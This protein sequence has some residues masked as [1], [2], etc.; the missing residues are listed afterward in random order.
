MSDDNVKNQPRKINPAQTFENLVEWVGTES[1]KHHAPGLIIGI[2]G[3]DSLLTYLACAEAYERQ[4]KG[5]RVLGLHFDH[6]A[7]AIP[8]AGSDKITCLKDEFNWVVR[9]ILPWLKSVAPE[10]KIEIDQ[11]LLLSDD[12]Q[13]WGKLFSRAIA[14]VP[15]GGEMTNQH[16]FPVG[17]RNAT[18]DYLGS[19]SQ[20]SKAV[21]MMPIVDLFKSEVMEICDYLQV[22]D[23]AMEKSREIDCACGRFDIPAFHMQELDWVIMNKK[24]MLSEAFLNENIDKDL[25]QDINAFVTE[26]RV[27]NAFRKETPYKPASS[28]IAEM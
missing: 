19:Y 26:E 10:A 6:V 25:L 2:S 18:E 9:D 11:T 27:L 8:E 24:G 21:S 1:K 14:D 15:Q 17:T 3:T 5:D 13:R 4:E 22:P 28:L 16:Y 12:N 23:I 7:E 20:I